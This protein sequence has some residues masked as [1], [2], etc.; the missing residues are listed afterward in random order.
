MVAFL[1]SDGT[2]SNS[3][4]APFR[5]RRLNHFRPHYAQE[6]IKD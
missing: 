4:Y 2:F 6:V 3:L 1:V 5:D